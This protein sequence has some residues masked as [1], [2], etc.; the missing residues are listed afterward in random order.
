ME[1]CYEQGRDDITIKVGIVRHKVQKTHALAAFYVKT[2][3]K[4]RGFGIVCYF[5]DSFWQLKRHDFV[6]IIVY[7]VYC[8]WEKIGVFLRIYKSGLKNT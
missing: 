6:S 7:I 3:Q 8:A 1:P 5:F 4:Q 2:A